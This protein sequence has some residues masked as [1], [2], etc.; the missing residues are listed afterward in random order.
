MFFNKAFQLF[1]DDQLFHTGSKLA[2]LL[3]RHGPCHAQLQ[4]GVSVTADFL[5]ILVGSGGGDDTDGIAAAFFDSV[6]ISCFRIFHQ[7]SGSR[8]HHRMAAL[9][10]AGHHDVLGN[11]L[12]VF[13]HHF[14]TLTG[15]HH[16]LGVGHTGT[17]L[18]QH[19][20]IKLL[21]KFISQLG[22]LKGFCRIGRLQHGDL[23]SSGIM[24]GILLILRRVHTRIIRDTDDE[25]GIDTGVGNGKQRV[26]RHIQTHVLHA[27]ER[28]AAC[29][30]RTEGR[31]QSNLFIGCPFCVHF[32]I[33]GDGFGNFRTGGTGVAG[34]KAASG[35]V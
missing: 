14:H 20:G 4:H 9:G 31:F 11:I 24:A 30:R 13:L 7:C 12:L 5:H 32:L 18:Q 10:I 21:R 29:Q 16:A 22:K 19:G 34:Y 27:A 15:L 3:F 2:D 6:N 8:F 26:R 23:G 25:T 17:H 28:P 35:F 33:F 1:H